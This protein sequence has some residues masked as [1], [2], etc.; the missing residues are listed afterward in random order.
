M[1]KINVFALGG[2]GVE[3]NGCCWIDV[4]FCNDAGLKY[5]SVDLYGVVRLFLY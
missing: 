4:V 2:L 1:S 5:P 3:K